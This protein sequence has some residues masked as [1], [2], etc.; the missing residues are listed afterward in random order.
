[1]EKA[2]KRL[3]QILAKHSSIPISDYKHLKIANTI[4]SHGKKRN[5]ILKYFRFVGCFIVLITLCQSDVLL[6]R[7]KCLL[8]AP[9]S[10][11]NLF[12]QPEDC[13]ICQSI[14]KIDKVYNISYQDFD[15]IYAKNSKPVLIK[16]ATQGWKAMEVFDFD[17]IKDLYSSVDNFQDPTCQFFR[18]KTEFN[19]LTEALNMSP[20]R[21]KLTAGEEPWYI[22]WS[23][24]NKEGEN[25][26]QDY[27]QKPYFLP[28]LSE[29]IAF[30]WIF[31]GGPGK[32]APLHVDNVLFPSWQAQIKGRKEWRLSPPPE[33]SFECKSMS[34]IVEPGDII[35]VDSNLWYHETII[36]PGE[37]SITIGAEF[38]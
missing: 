7:K 33:C 31:M 22:G 6:T 23:N 13:N 34:V 25:I 4:I 8:S 1:M 36:L 28:S 35:A 24:C 11:T 26:L 32:G 29:N 21:A 9:P 38:D 27:F 17:F 3:S 20:A 10:F 16:N 5:R 19:S 2:Q 12:R 15:R 18:Y 37:L 14:T 30:S